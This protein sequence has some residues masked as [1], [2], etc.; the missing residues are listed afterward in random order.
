[1]IRTLRVFSIIL[2]CTGVAYAVDLTGTITDIDGAPLPGAN[3]SVLAPGQEPAGSVA[4]LDGRYS[5][6]DLAAGSYKL[7]VTYIGYRTATFEDVK[8]DGQVKRFD[9][10]LESSVIDLEQS[11]V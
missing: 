10:K 7:R 5:V 1:M 6:V 2:V 9:V 4:G 8:V 3:I 11:I